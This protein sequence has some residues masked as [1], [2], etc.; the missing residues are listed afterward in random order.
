MYEYTRKRS[1]N[2]GALLSVSGDTTRPEIRDAVLLSESSGTLRFNS[3]SM[4]ATGSDELVGL[5]HRLASYFGHEGPTDDIPSTCKSAVLLSRTGRNGTRRSGPD[6]ASDAAR[7]L[8]AVAAYGIVPLP[9]EWTPVR[10]RLVQDEDTE[11]DL[12]NGH[13]LHK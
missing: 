2:G 6:R 13:I 10:G 5:T 12:E 4:I 9:V 7:P 1:R 11:G 8:L 3:Y